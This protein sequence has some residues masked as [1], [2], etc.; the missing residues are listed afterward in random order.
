MD[1]LIQ[2][3]H[4]IVFGTLGFLVFFAIGKLSKR[5]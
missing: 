5:R 4:L 1:N 3:W 2:P